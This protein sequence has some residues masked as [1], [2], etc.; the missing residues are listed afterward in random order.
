[1]YDFEG[2]EPADFRVSF[3]LAGDKGI[4]MNDVEDWLE[5]MREIL[6]M[7]IILES[8]LLRMFPLLKLM[9]KKSKNL[10]NY[11]L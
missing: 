5:L 8:K 10:H 4:S 7:R 3:S 11:H 6:V 1:V 9:M 2:F